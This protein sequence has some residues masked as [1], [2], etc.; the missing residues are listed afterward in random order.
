MIRQTISR[1]RNELPMLMHSNE[2]ECFDERTGFDE[3]PE[4]LNFED[5]EHFLTNFAKKVKK[6]D[7][8]EDRTKIIF[9]VCRLLLIS[10]LRIC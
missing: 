2:L 10:H 8:I 5:C 9:A 7:R 6:Y 3:I 4:T 1:Q